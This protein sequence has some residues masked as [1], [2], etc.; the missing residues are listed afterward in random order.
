MSHTVTAV[1]PIPSSLPTWSA[2]PPVTVT[3]MATIASINSRAMVIS[4]RVGT[5]FQIGRPSPT[6]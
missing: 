6:S 4:T 5:V 1:P 3:P 2:R